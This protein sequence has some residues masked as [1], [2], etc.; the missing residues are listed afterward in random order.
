MYTDHQ[1]SI[2]Q[3]ALASPA[4]FRRTVTFVLASVKRYFFDV[5]QAMDKPEV[6]TPASREGYACIM[7]AA[8]A[9][10][11]FAQGHATPMERMR[12]YLEI[13]GLGI[14]KAGFLCQLIHGQVGCLDTH[15]LRRFGLS[16]TAFRTPNTAKALS[17]RLEVYLHTCDG[18]GGGPEALW[19]DWC[20]VQSQLYPEQWRDD[21]HVSRYHAECI[22]QPD[23]VLADVEW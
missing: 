6:F 15:N 23:Q 22:I 14:C 2:S 4:H 21:E 16:P 3:Y 1:P 19:N 5:Q 9:Y 20:Y 18:V 13:P 10:W 17:E 8:P 11:S 7:E 12:R